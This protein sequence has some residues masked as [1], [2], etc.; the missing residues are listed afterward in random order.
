MRK[1]PEDHHAEEQN[2]RELSQTHSKLESAASSW[3]MTICFKMSILFSCRTL[4]LDVC[5]QSE[6]KRESELD[7]GTKMEVQ[8]PRT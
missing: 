1:A 6:S 4:R 2:T 8:H 5:L 7:I 3:E